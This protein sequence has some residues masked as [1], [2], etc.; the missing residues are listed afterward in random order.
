MTNRGARRSIYTSKQKANSVENS[1]RQGCQS[2]I[3]LVLKTRLINNLHELTQR[4]RIENYI[5]SETKEAARTFPVLF[6]E[7]LLNRVPKGVPDD[8]ILLQFMPSP[9]ELETTH[10]FSCDPLNEQTQDSSE[11]QTNEP[12]FILKKYYGRVL[13]IATNACAC[14]CRFC[15]RRYFPKDRALFPFTEQRTV[16]TCDQQNKAVSYLHHVFESIQK[17]ETISEIILSGGDPLTLSNNNLKFLLHYIGTITHV[18]RVRIHSR[19]PVLAPQ[20]IDEDFPTLEDFHS[21]NLCDPRT[22]HLVLHVNTPG[23]IDED[24]AKALSTLRRKGFILTSQTTLLKG[25]NDDAETLVTLYE[26]LINLGTLPYYLHQLDK[27][28]GAAHFETSVALGKEI[29]KQLSSRLPGYA[30]PRYV[31]EIPGKPMKT[32]LFIE[33]G[34]D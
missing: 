30:V 6:P 23:E 21:Q 27:V 12:P 14:Q 3:E 1:L 29:I 19:V 28:Q 2:E 17:D 11:R 22:L 16:K 33:Q 5:T 31:R 8:P 25:V 32:N 18:K 13:I 7:S 34:C 24:V 9:Q 20:R 4:L 26:K 10:G 15:F